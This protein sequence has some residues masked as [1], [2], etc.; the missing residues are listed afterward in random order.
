[1]TQTPQPPRDWQKDM[2][3]ILREKERVQI[4]HLDTK[5]EDI[6]I[7]W[8]QEAKRQQESLDIAHMAYEGL[9]EDCVS[10]GEYASLIGKLTSMTDARKAEKARAD[11]AKELLLDTIGTMMAYDVPALH[12]NRIVKEFSTLYP[13]T[14]A[15]TTTKDGSHEI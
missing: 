14:P 8:L 6:A 15:P 7:H 13:D 3:F 5:E 9:Q 10:R 4:F 1:M 12:R 11:A 2:A